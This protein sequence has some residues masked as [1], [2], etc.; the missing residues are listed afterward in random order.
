[1][2]LDIHLLKLFPL[3]D[4]NCR[5]VLNLNLHR[6]PSCTAG[7]RSS[8]RARVI[9]DDR[10]DELPPQRVYSG[11]SV[12]AGYPEEGGGGGRGAVRYVEDEYYDDGYAEPVAPVRCD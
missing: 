6:F 9:V 12:G 11:R 4:P 3:P 2:L 5:L 10:Y 7:G 8:E 1:M